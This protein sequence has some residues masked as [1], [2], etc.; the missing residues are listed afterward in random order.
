M[1]SDTRSDEE[2]QDA[3]SEDAEAQVDAPPQDL[4]E[5]VLDQT[6][7][8]QVEAASDVTYATDAALGTQRPEQNIQWRVKAG[9]YR[10]EQWAKVKARFAPDGGA[11]T[12]PLSS[13]TPK[14]NP[15]QHGTYLRRLE[16]VVKDPQNLNI[17]LTGRY[18]AGKSSVLDEFQRRHGRGTQRLA[19]STLTPEADADA[20]DQAGGKAS[21]RTQI[22]TTN[23]IQKEVVKQLLYGAPPRVE[24][25]SRFSRISV[26]TLRRA[27]VQ[28]GVVVAAVGVLL[29]LL[30]WLPNLKWTGPD[31]QT[32]VR[33][34]AWIGAWVVATG[35][36]TAVRMATYGRFVSNVS[37]AGTAL[38]LT[39]RPQTMFDKFLDEIVHYFDYGSKD[40]VVFEDLD[41]FENPEIF[42]ALRELNTLLN[43]TPRRRTRRRGRPLPRA[44][45]WVLLQL[46]IYSFLDVRLSDRWAARL[47]GRGV[48]LRFIYAVK[49]SLFERLGADTNAL[50]DAGDAVA[51][52]TLR[53]N[54]TKFFDVVVP[55]VPFISHRNARELL[56]Q[57]LKEFGITK[58]DKKLVNVVAQHSTDMRLLRN[59]CNEYLIF[60]ERLLRSENVA[61]DLDQSR[62]FALVAYKNFHLADFENISRRESDLDTL[63][64][65]HQ[66]IVR[67]SIEW[68]E[69]RARYAP[70][71]AAAKRAE[72]AKV[73]G[74]RLV[75]YAN[76]R[77]ASFPQQNYQAQQYRYLFWKTVD[78]V[79][80]VDAAQE[81]G[82]WAS[83]G[84]AYEFEAKVS[85]DEG[86]TNSRTL[87][88]LA[89]PDLE[90]M[91]PEALTAGQWE[92]LDKQ[93]TVAE[94]ARIERDLGRLRSAD[95]EQLARMPQF[96]LEVSLPA[97]PDAGENGPTGPAPSETK[98]A[99]FAQLIESTLKSPLAH[100]LVKRGY[101]DRNYSLYAAQFY[102]HFTGTDVATFMV[103]HVQTNTMSIDYD[104]KRPGAVANL[105]D[106]VR[107]TGEDLSTTRV[108]FNIHIVDHL[109]A[110]DHP[111]VADVVER[112]VTEHDDDARSFLAAY[113][114]SG[115]RP[116][117][118]AARLAAYPWR[119][120]FVYLCTDPEVGEA[121]RP[122]LVNAALKS[123]AK[124]ADYDLS[125]EVRDFIERQY[126]AMGAFT[127]PQEQKN[128]AAVLTLLESMGAK[129]AELAPLADSLQSA[130]VEA[131][132]YPLDAANLRAAL[133]TE[134]ISLDEALDRPEI[135]AYCLEEIETY[136]NAVDQLDEYHAGESTSW[137]VQSPE[138]LAKVLTDL[139]DD[140]D[141][142]ELRK[143]AN[144]LAER[145]TAD[146]CLDNLVD[147]PSSSW[148]ALAQKHLF[149]P[150]LDN[151]HNYRVQ[152]G[153]IDDNLASLLEVTGVIDTSA[154]PDDHD[155]DAEALAMLNAANITDTGT[156]VALAQSL[157]PGLPL[158]VDRI[159][160]ESTDLFAR[161]L[162]EDMVE[163]TAES[164]EHFRAAGWQS[165]GPAIRASDR[166]ATFVTPE[167]VEG[168][169]GDILKDP[170]ASAKLASD[171]MGDVDGYAPDGDHDALRAVGRHAGSQR[172]ALPPAT[173][174]RIAR[175]Q[176]TDQSLVLGLLHGAEPAPTPDEIVSTFVAMGGDYAK[177]ANS[178]EKFT[179]P[180]GPATAALLKSLKDA[181]ILTPRK[182]GESISVTVK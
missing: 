171:V 87:F 158:P 91:F 145:T 55:L 119:E 61:P 152:V 149:S 80:D 139:G 97:Q 147:A 170:T 73:L 120:T 34:C 26:L 68:L 39:E 3:S 29:F 168:M 90:I 126:T 7:K 99:S 88:S 71:A 118:L 15:E 25:N 166:I 136:I 104:L 172:I 2:T 78:G 132:A 72:I 163:D 103:Q 43:D 129:L 38:S 111:A 93:A 89:Q 160:P 57:L 117:L 58:I 48:P 83:V 169:V 46:H 16:E 52:E 131:H 154:G 112:L 77:R 60:E 17:A 150:T 173:V 134:D 128:T 32:W 12:Q 27:A 74:E 142:E 67:T 79:F 143:V 19:I 66:R 180:Y 28:S 82:F 22:A 125:D 127:S 114:T 107:E 85:A 141:A 92:K 137:A 76:A 179:L 70:Q 161:L 130:A 6:S 94:L 56:D 178:G 110:E 35:L 30:G 21:T 140:R 115:S 64:S 174:T 175:A 1:S 86:R 155:V 153:E 102:G 95:F 33:A 81:P 18:G 75:R 121:Q 106:E 36:A 176:A 51:G 40:I 124:P 177:V 13:L 23:R 146:V 182:R 49:D 53:A 138:T 164:F 9:Q 181:S 31:E 24:K 47:L 123:A 10:R 11:V 157:D 44:L 167:L 14:Y 151:V 69:T 135:Y 100:E 5:G 101:L 98:Q 96:T 62:L 8:D 45:G 109:L 144:L 113:F 65:Y 156:R 41:R 159:S 108:A 165:I 59:I 63:Y 162:T 20:A 105:L 84:S 37:A 50:V 4:S 148:P 42:E 122:A 133:G 116:A 54:R